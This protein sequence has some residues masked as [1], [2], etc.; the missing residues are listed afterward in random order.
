M[1]SRPAIRQVPAATVSAIRPPA[2]RCAE[3]HHLGNGGDVGTGAAAVPQRTRASLGFISSITWP[4]PAARQITIA[5]YNAPAGPHCSRVRQ[6]GSSDP[7]NLAYDLHLQIPGRSGHPSIVVPKPRI[8]S[9]VSL[10]GRV[11]Q[12]ALPFSS[13]GSRP[14]RTW[15][16]ITDT[17]RMNMAGLRSEAQNGL[18]GLDLERVHACQRHIS[19]IR[20]QVRRACSSLAPSGHYRP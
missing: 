18:P 20:C 7:S 5:P 13:S 12:R 1:I 4:T 11:L 6:A 10:R 3:Q 2:S 9:L 15:H 14:G 8:E 19:N 16:R 17:S